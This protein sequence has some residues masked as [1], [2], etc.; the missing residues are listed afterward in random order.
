MI[1]K[2]CFSV[3]KKETDFCYDIISSTLIKA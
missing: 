2:K 1:R 3:S